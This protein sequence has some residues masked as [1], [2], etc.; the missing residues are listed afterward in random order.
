[1]L[2]LLPV[3]HPFKP[4]AKHRA[5]F[6]NLLQ[7]LFAENG[8][9][10]KWCFHYHLFQTCHLKATPVFDLRDVSDHE[11]FSVIC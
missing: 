5:A 9:V 11:N 1:M 8:T 3:L 6:V 10:S 2:I 4:L 7:G